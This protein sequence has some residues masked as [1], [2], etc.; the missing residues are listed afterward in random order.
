MDTLIAD[1]KLLLENHFTVVEDNLLNN[2]TKTLLKNTR[3]SIR[4]G[5]WKT[6]L[7]FLQR[8][9]YQV[10]SVMQ[11]YYGACQKGDE[12]LINLFSSRF[13]NKPIYGLRHLAKYKHYKILNKLKTSDPSEDFV[14]LDGLICGNDLETLKSKELIDLD[15]YQNEIVVGDNTYRLYECIEL[16]FKHNNPEMIDY[17]RSKFLPIFNSGVVDRYIMRGKIQG[18]QVLN[19]DV[20]K[21]CV[22]NKFYMSDVY[23]LTKFG[24]YEIVERL[25]DEFYPNDDNYIAQYVQTLM[26]NNRTDLVE[27]YF[28]KHLRDVMRDVI[29]LLVALRT[30]NLELFE[31]H[32]TSKIY[33]SIERITELAIE[34]SAYNIVWYLFSNKKFDANLV[35]IKYSI[36]DP[37]LARLLI[38]HMP[39]YRFS[40]S[41]I[42]R[43]CIAHHYD[44]VAKILLQN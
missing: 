15:K 5:D 23:C 3:K 28:T 41:H 6:V 10:Y 42:V 26:M 34:Y 38:Q 44:I 16:L 1:L 43:E 25:I 9:E 12:Q 18:H 39:S 19:Y 4:I 27:S 31:K 30:N 32:Y 24:H 17:V 21:Q 14:I 35:S 11:A 7:Y 33:L 20:L 8:Y 29:M 2:K 37:R 40:R 36:R 22:M 13:K